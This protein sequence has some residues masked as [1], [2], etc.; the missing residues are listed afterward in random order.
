M[1]SLLNF[2]QIYQLVRKLLMGAHRQTG[3]LI[4][5]PFIYQGKEAKTHHRREYKISSL[6][7][8]LHYFSPVHNISNNFLVSHFNIIC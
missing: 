7:S 1:T 2:M 8:I 3:N 6:D 4:N 5:L